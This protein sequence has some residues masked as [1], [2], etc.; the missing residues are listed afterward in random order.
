ML[1][2]VENAIEELDK[3]NPSQPMESIENVKTSLK[4]AATITQTLLIKKEHHEQLNHMSKELSEIKR[5]LTKPRTY[6][7]AAA[8]ETQRGSEHN[9]E[10][11]A[12]HG[13]PIQ[14][15]MASIN[16]S[17]RNTQSQ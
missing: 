1:K 8:T 12:N 14:K 9:R 6:A 16:K 15:R 2:L 7:Q 11:P 17:E 13:R 10:M 4:K 3:S 5:L